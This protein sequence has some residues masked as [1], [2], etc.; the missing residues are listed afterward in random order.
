MK[1]AKIRFISFVLA[2][3]TPFI[4]LKTNSKGN[5]YSEYISMVTSVLDTYNLADSY[6]TDYNADLI[7]YAA[8]H[9][10]SKHKEEIIDIQHLCNI[11]EENSNNYGNYSPFLNG[12]LSK[13]DYDLFYKCFVDAINTCLSS[14]NNLSEDYCKFKSLKIAFKEIP[15]K[16]IIAN[17]N[18]NDN[19]ITVDLE[20][21]KLVYPLSYPQQEISFEQYLFYTLLHELDHVKQ[22]K[23]DCR[24]NQPNKTV[25]VKCFSSFIESSAESAIY[26]YYGIEDDEYNGPYENLRK[27]E[28]LV[29]LM[30]TFKENRTVNQYYDAIFDADIEKLLDYFGV[31]SKDEIKTFYNIFYT[32]DVLNT[33]FGTSNL[34]SYDN[35]S[36]VSKQIGQ[37]YK[38]DILKNSVSDLINSIVK[39]EL[40]I[41]QSLF[42]YNFVKTTIYC[43][44]L[45]NNDDDFLN[46]VKEVEDIFYS[47]LS[48][49]YNL[50]REEIQ[51]FISL[52]MYA[53]FADLEA[54]NDNE[55]KVLIEKFPLLTVISKT[56]KPDYLQLILY[57][58][59]NEKSR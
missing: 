45:L 41:K 50:N 52:D 16:T 30:A 59:L 17:C 5:D 56:N 54:C 14:T 47:F 35:A 57:E 44:D 25:R 42:L 46:C 11:I 13:E 43:Y 9:T 38:S 19:L 37:A 28:C 21:I 2:L 8:N 51:S 31:K 55:I 32:F 58:E 6:N 24:T 49:Y 18:N 22:Q 3:T 29:L 4:L 36:Y 48:D 23:C 53:Y 20:K 12:S 33:S 40:T 26:N 1:N 39:E 7:R 34:G 10:V 15:D 27:Q